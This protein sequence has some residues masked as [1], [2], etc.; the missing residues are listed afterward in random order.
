MGYFL[1][2]DAGGTKT[3]CALGD[4]ERLLVRARGGSIKPLR[5]LPEEAH[6]NLKALLEDVTAQA[7]TTLN[8]IT[9]TSIGIAGLR[10]PETRPWLTGLLS[11]LVSGTIEVCGDE[12]IALDGAFQGRPGVLLIAGTGSNI[13]ARTSAGALLTVGGWGPAIGDEG[14]GYWIGHEGLSASFRAYDRGEPAPLLD[15]TIAAWSATS[16]QEV[17]AIANR[18]PFPDFSLL[19]PLVVECA[20]QGDPTCRDILLAAG[21]W[22]AEFATRAYGKLLAAEGSSEKIAGI[23][24]IGS[25]VGKVRLVRE[26]MLA[27]LRRNLPSASIFEDEVDAVAGALWRARHLELRSQTVAR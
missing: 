11:S 17:V 23:A 12:E 13:L 27:E 18:R 25:I 21:R 20:D 6:D 26:T 10:F 1:G 15:R 8:Q 14:S 7:G 5:V 22:L 9:A 24:F 2:I 19:A 16:L 3:A 4:E